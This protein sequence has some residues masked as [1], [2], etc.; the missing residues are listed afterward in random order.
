MT[1]VYLICFLLITVGAV[2]LL[3]LTPERITSDLMRFVSPKQTL[4][5]KVLTIK[6][7]K[8]SRKLTVELN[9]IR[10]ALAK[11]G[12][13]GQFAIACAASILLMV[14]GCVVAIMIDNAFLI[15]VFAIAFALIPFAYAKRTV[16]FYDN[17]IKEELETALS[18]ITTSYVRTDDIVTAVKENVQYLK[19]PVKDIFA[20]FVA[21]NMMIS[22]DIK[23]SIRHLKEKVGNSIFDEWCDT[24]VSCQD[25]RTLKDTLMPIVAKLTDVRI[26]NNE[27]KGMLMAART[28]YWMMAAMVVGNI[29]LLYIINKD[30]YAALMFTTLGKIVLAV[31]GLTII[32]TALLMFKYTKQVEFRK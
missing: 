3:K 9:R 6:G 32:V 24:L 18:I 25:D 12:K 15:P 29:P 1:F 17:H 28:E 7:K 4:R 20:S 22:S 10:D 8:K 5:D 31:C 11:T 14:I 23:Q 19:P 26:V 13:G 27:I 16:S 2:I 21:E 30:W